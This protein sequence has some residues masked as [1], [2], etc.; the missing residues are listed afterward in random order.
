MKKIIFNTLTIKNFLSIGE[1]PVKINFKSGLHGITG[2]NKD[3]FDRRNGVGKSTIPDA[4]YFALFGTTIR[5]LKKEFIINNITGKTCEVS[6]LFSIIK[7]KEK[8]NYEIIRTL[9]PSKCMLYQNDRDITRDSI[10][11]TTQYI[12]EL[13]Q[14]TPE[15][16]QNCVIMTVNNTVPFMAKKKTEKRKFIEGIFNL[17]I[18]SKML[19]QLRDEY[20]EVKKTLDVEN[21]KQEEVETSVATLMQQKE[22]THREYEDRKNTLLKRKDDITKEIFSINE[23]ISSFTP[24]NEDEVNKNLNLLA[25]KS[26]ECDNKIHELGKNI[27]ALETKNEFVVGSLAKIGTE[28]DI[29]PTCLRQVEDQDKQ[30]IHKTITV[31]KTELK[32]R[33]S[34]IRG[35]ESK[36]SEMNTLKAK[37]VDAIK[38]GQ[39]SISKNNLLKQQHKNDLEKIKQIDELNGQIE[40]DLKHLSDSSTTMDNLITDTGDKL[41]KIKEKTNGLRK[42]INLLDTVKFVVSEEGV[43]SFIVKRILKLFNSKLASYLKRLNSNAIITFNEYF[44]DTIINAKGKETTYFNFSGAERKVIDLAIMFSFIDMLSLQ[45]NIYYNIQFYDELLDTSLDEAGVELVLRLLAEFVEKNGFGVYIITHRKECSRLVSG[46]T[47]YLEKQN[48][49]TTLG[50]Y[51]NS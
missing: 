37:I 21:A 28:D 32:Q 10:V 4:L 23:R 38:K 45:G 33:E 6:L 12:C 49:I 50:K 16:F 46:E 39:N 5:E 35:F 34:E 43:K 20:N 31:Y 2:I 25:N 13:I 47:I 29:C 36:L 11:N 9:E 1:T 44:E 15:I 30:H 18:F 26:Q 14:C 27:A 7:G 41:T 48:G 51:T 24:I 19:L 17:E 22:K 40:Q 8:T 42:V 3:Q